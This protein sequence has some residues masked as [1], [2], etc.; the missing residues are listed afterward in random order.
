MMV[1]CD[2]NPASEICYAGR[3]PEEQQ[4]AIS[5]LSFFRGHS[6]CKSKMLTTRERQNE[7][8]EKRCLGTFA[9]QLRFEF[10]VVKLYLCLFH[11][12]VHINIHRNCAS[13]DTKPFAHTNLTFK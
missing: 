12:S 9:L 8:R 11:F 7:K 3:Q 13:N 2:H 4:Q 1:V 10:A 5:V 6:E